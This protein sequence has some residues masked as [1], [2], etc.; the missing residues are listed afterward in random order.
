MYSA[1]QRNPINQNTLCQSSINTLLYVDESKDPHEVRWLDCS[2][3]PPK[4]ATDT[5]IIH[6]EE[7]SPADMCYVQHRNKQ[8]FI[9]TGGSHG[10]AAYNTSSNKMEWTY[11]GEVAKMKMDI[12]ACGATTDGLGYLFVCDT[13]NKCIQTFSTDGM[14]LGCLLKKGQKGLGE[15]RRICWCNSTSSLI[16]AHKK[17]S[18]YHIST[19]NIQ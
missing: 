9:T 6:I 4:A 14:Y 7:W 16:V 3:L 12:F 13:N 18:R 11:K 5:N 10:I 17:S 2:T 1:T 15:P 19:I 8:L